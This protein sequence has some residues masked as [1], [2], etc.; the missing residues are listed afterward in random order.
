MLLRRVMAFKRPRVVCPEVAGLAVESLHSW[1][2]GLFVPGLPA[3]SLVPYCW[4][5]LQGL[6][7][8]CLPPFRASFQQNNLTLSRCPFKQ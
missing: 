4:D 7:C 1:L 6:G 8:C 2:F 3:T 5:N